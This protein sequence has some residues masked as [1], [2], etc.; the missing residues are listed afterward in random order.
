MTDRIEPTRRQRYSAAIGLGA[1]LGEPERAFK[2]ALALLERDGDVLVLRRSSW[3]ATAA[4][5]AP[6]QPEYLNGAVLVET[7]LAPHALLE[8]LR[9]IEAHIGRDRSNE[10]RFGPRVLDLDLL[11]VVD[12]GGQEVVLRDEALALPHPR[13]DERDFVLVPLVEIAPDHVLSRSGVPV[14]DQLERLRD[15]GGIVRLASPAQARVWCRA[16]TADGGTLGFIPTMGALHDGHL[17]LVR[18]AARENDRVCVS[19]FVNPLQFNDPKDLER[20]PR[21]FDA[22]ARK[23]ASAGASMV[24]TGSLEEFFPGEVQSGALVEAAFVAP[25]PAAEGLEGTFRPGHF[26]GVATIVDRLFDVTEPTRAYFGAKDFQ[27]CLVVEH[28]ARLRGGAPEVLRCSTVRSSLG[29]ALSS[30]NEQLSGDARDKALIL[31]RALIVVR[32]AW[33]S[34]LRDAEVLADMLRAEVKDPAVDVEYAEVRDPEAWS[35]EAPSG[36]IKRA[37]ALVAANVGGVRLIDNM[38]LD[39]PAS[40]SA[41]VAVTESSAQVR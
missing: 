27:Q 33:R 35:A 25:G 12:G 8:K 30:R 36:L 4:V 20:Y 18:R 41:P 2:R 24:F 21:D 7:R 23:L 11:F 17:E 39:E 38:R 16:A 29:L 37:V 26:R 14:R 6:D 15:G 1:N 22:D 5:G 28:V 31:S 9:E 32:S 3:H 10:V 13:M 40:E 19:I 34:G